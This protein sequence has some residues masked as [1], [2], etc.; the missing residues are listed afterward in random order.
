MVFSQVQHVFI[1]QQYFSTRPYAQV[2]RSL[3][4]RYPDALNINA[5]TISRLVDHFRETGGVHDRKRSGRSS[6]LTDEKTEDVKERLQ[7]ISEEKSQETCIR[8][9]NV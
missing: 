2:K 7:K 9:T 6:V 5:M 3:Q 1:L 4:A 8:G